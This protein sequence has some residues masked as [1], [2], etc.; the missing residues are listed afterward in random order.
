MHTFQPVYEVHSIAAFHLLVPS[1]SMLLVALLK[2]AKLLQDLQ[3][4]SVIQG[5]TMSY[6]KV[7]YYLLQYTQHC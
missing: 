5:I 4:K 1:F 2:Q 7:S 6:L 3:L